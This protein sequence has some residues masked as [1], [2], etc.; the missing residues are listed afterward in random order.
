MGRPEEFRRM[1]YDTLVEP[2]AVED[3][4]LWVRFWSPGRGRLVEASAE[5]PARTTAEEGA[6]ACREGRLVLTGRGRLAWARA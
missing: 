1:S 2:L 6:R 5:L 4:R 3:G